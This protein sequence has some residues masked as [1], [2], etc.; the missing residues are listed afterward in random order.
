MREKADSFTT[1]GQNFEDVITR[2]RSLVNNLQEEWE[3]DASNSFKVRYEELEKG[4]Q[5]AKDLIIDIAAAL[6]KTAQIYEDADASIRDAY[7]S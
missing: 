1:E 6:N 3:G 7:S 2:M 5:A 4:F